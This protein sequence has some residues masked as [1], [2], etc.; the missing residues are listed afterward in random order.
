MF[1]EQDVHEEAEQDV[2]E[3]EEKKT[4]RKVSLVA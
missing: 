1:L 2:R 3:E 4:E